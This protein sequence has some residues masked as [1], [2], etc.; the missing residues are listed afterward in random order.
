MAKNNLLNTLQEKFPRL[1]L[2]KNDNLD[3]IA[4]IEEFDAKKLLHPLYKPE[5]FDESLLNEII[6]LIPK[7]EISEDIL[8]MYIFLKNNI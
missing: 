3:N 4:D 5:G 7:E 1:I 2:E 6:D 8:K